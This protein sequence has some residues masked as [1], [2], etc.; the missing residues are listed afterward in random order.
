MEGDARRG[1]EINAT[2][3]KDY[4][5][6]APPNTKIWCRV[7][8]LLRQLASNDTTRAQCSKNKQY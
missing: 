7:P 2:S 6:K 3:I 4:Q 5:K 1:V 8:Q